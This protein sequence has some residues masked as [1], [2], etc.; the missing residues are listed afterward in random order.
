MNQFAGRPVRLAFA[1]GVLLFWSAV[2]PG[3]AG[4]DR[5]YTSTPEA[6][7]ARVV[8]RPTYSEPGAKAVFLGGYA[9]A[10]YSRGAARAAAASRGR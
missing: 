9:G 1:A 6:G 3:C 7:V 4:R 2:A 10:D 5:Y 8:Q